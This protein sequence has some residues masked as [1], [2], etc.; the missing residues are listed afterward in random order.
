LAHLKAEL[1]F[2]LSNQLLIQYDPS[3]TIHHIP[4]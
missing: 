4:R 2:F 1:V 3:I